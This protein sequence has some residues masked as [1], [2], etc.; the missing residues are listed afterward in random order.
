MVVML[1]YDSRGRASALRSTKKQTFYNASFFGFYQQFNNLIQPLDVTTFARQT[2]E[3][4][5]VVHT[6][7]NIDVNLNKIHN[8]KNISLAA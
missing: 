3:K 2:P 5:L 8:R 4:N 1:Y 7:K 6:V